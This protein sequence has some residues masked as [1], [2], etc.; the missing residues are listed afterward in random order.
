MALGVGI[1]M[2][3]CRSERILVGSYLLAVDFARLHSNYS[4]D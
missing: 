1:L 2:G 3:L 4:Q